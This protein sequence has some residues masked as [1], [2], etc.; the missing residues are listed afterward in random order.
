[1]ISEQLK[2]QVVCAKASLLI[3]V[4][5]QGANVISNAE[6]LTTTV[7]GLIEAIERDDNGT[8]PEQVAELLA[9]VEKLGV[10]TVQYKLNPRSPEHL[11]DM[12]DAVESVATVAAKGGG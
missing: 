12:L 3:C 10:A 1:M 7:H 5:P 11:I 2:S 9:V 4:L 6:L 8:T